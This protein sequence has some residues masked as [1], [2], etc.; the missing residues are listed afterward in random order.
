MQT[1]ATDRIEKAAVLRAPRSRVWRALSDVREFSAW[2]LTNFEGEFTKGAVVRGRPT[3]P[4]YEHLTIEIRIERMEPERHFS[5][6]WHPYEVDLSKDASS[7]P[8]TLV[9][10]TLE[11]RRKAPGSQWSSR[12]ST[13]CLPGGASRRSARTRADGPNRCRTSR[14]M[15]RGRSAGPAR[16]RESAPVFAALGDATR[17]RLVERLCAEGPLSITRLSEDMDVTRQAVTKHLVALAGAG[18]A[19]PRREGREQIWELETRRLALARQT[20]DQISG[21]WDSAIARLRAFV[22]D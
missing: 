14:G 11:E 9:E 4:G 21:Q 19:R 1:T 8:T 5:F 17:L 10:F 16:L 2:F 22:E 6:R 12:G 15:S 3:N 13:P 20:L 18:L 7:E